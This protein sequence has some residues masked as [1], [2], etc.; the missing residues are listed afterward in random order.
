MDEVTLSKGHANHKA[1]FARAL[2]ELD[3]DKVPI[4]GVCIRSP[5][6]E[7]FQKFTLENAPPRCEGCQK[8]IVHDR[9]LNCV[10]RCLEKG[11]NI[12][13]SPRDSSAT[14]PRLMKSPASMPQSEWTMVKQRNQGRREPR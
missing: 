9:C 6:G 1:V 11:K 4:D 5:D 12:D 2:V 3:L 13:E 8:F 10:T 7:R 14:G